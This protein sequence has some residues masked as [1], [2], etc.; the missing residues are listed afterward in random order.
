LTERFS[1][2]ISEYCLVSQTSLYEEN[3]L[4][5]LGFFREVLRFCFY[6]IP[7]FEYN[8]LLDIFLKNF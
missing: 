3:H 8:T 1:I 6:F 5:D 4:F 7:L 2:A